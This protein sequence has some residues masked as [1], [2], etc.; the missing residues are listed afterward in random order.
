[1]PTYAA[2]KSDPGLIVDAPHVM[3]VETYGIFDVSYFTRAAPARVARARRAT[4]PLRRR[5][6]AQARVGEPALLHRGLLLHARTRRRAGQVGRRRDL[7]DAGL[8]HGADDPGRRR[9][10]GRRAARAPRL[11]LF[12]PERAAG[13]PRRL[14]PISLAVKAADGKK[15]DMMKSVMELAWKVSVID[16]QHVLASACRKITVDHG[17][18]EALRMERAKALREVPRPASG[19]PKKRA[20]IRERRSARSSS[21]APRP[22]A[23]RRPGRRSSPS[24]WATSTK[25]G[26]FP[27]T[28]P[29]LSPHKHSSARTSVR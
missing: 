11:F 12:F 20:R 23:T 3:I 14:T 2:D 4:P 15:A 27:S 26:P 6:V 17:A 18:S 7:P 9:P 24:T 10:R 28:P 8:R 22:A 5:G 21:S 1:M 16:V 29:S 13:A 19:F 25:G